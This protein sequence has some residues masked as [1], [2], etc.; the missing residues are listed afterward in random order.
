MK[1]RHHIVVETAHLKYEFDIKRNITVIQGD[2]AT[3]K[4]TLADLLGEYSARGAG[5]GIRLESDAACEVFSGP[6]RNWQYTLDGFH[7]AIVLIDEDYHFVYTKTFAE[8]IQGSENYYVI[9]SRRPLK[10]LPYS[11]TE[12]Y[13]IRTT[14]KYHFPDQVYHEF[15]PLYPERGLTSDGSR[16]L[17]LIEDEKAEYQFFQDTLGSERCRSA[18]G[19]ANV[20]S[21]VAEYASEDG[22][23]VVADGAAF[24]AYIDAVVKMRDLKK[25]IALYFPESFEWMILRSGVLEDAGLKEI[26][27]HP[28]DFIDSSEYVSWERYF[29]ALLRRKTEGDPLRQ[30]SKSALPKFYTTG[31]NA[32]MI[33]DVMPEEIR[34]LII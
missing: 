10:N 16:V 17:L 32:A 18:G 23:L 30:Y 8:Y 26:L 12:I 33:L 20:Y 24:G 1:G 15:Y 21:G 9:I 22:L 13:G 31:R 29:T 28:E 25:H 6:E 5:R 14:G 27:S 3:G 2:S 34:R 19:N 11:I 4:T 7:D